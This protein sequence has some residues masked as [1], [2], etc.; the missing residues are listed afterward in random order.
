MRSMYIPGLLALAAC[1]A[2]TCATQNARAQENDREGIVRV[3]D[4][5]PAGDSLHGSTDC[6]T[7]TCPDGAC[8]GG[9][10]GH[11]SHG[12]YGY[13]GGHGGA[14]CRHGYGG[15]CSLC[16]SGYGH[17][18]GPFCQHLHQKLSV[19]SLNGPCTFSPDHGWAPPGK[20][21]VEQVGVAYNKFFPASWMGHK[22]AHAPARPLP[23]IYM[24]TD[25]TQLGY[26]YQQVPQWLPYPN[27]VPPVPHP[28]EWHVPLCAVNPNGY[29]PGH[30][31]AC[32]PGGYVTGAPVYEG[33]IQPTPANKP[34]QAPGHDLPE[35]E[36]PPPPTEAELERSASAPA[37]IPIPQ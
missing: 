24:P 12:T 1:T 23:Q 21:P 22:H 11:G 18:R 29:G 8:P 3:S 31:Q 15:H 27:M 10:C 26:Y 5:A 13:H 37:L 2:L 32:P 14:W 6:P 33:S 7:G 36:A 35:G 34:G 4:C 30:G 19:L 28:A 25:T 16:G 9:V 20:I 17:C